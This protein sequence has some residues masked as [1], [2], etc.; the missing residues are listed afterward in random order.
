LTVCATCD[1]IILALSAAADSS[2][3][4]EDTQTVLVD[5]HVFFF[6]VH[7][8]KIGKPSS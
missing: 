4:Q 6:S 3:L 2:D 8:V 7:D 1:V 5:L